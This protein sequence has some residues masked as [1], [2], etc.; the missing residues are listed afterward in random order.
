MP[1]ALS[2]LVRQAECQ[3]SIVTLPASAM[4]SDAVMVWCNDGVVLP[5]ALSHHGQQAHTHEVFL[6]AALIDTNSV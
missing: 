3:L 1:G 4:A 2:H 6:R 5:G